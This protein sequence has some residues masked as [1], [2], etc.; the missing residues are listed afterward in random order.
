M[1]KVTA[2]LKQLRHFNENLRTLAEDAEKICKMSL[3]D[4]MTIA[5]DELRKSVEGL[6]TVSNAQALAAYQR[7]E[8]T[9][10]SDRQ[11]AA[12]A[13]GLGVSPMRKRGQA[14]DN[15]V[16]FE[17]YNDVVTRRWPS[18]QP[19]QMIAASCEHGS[20]AMLAQPF[21]RPAFERCRER[22][23]KRMTDTAT[24]EIEKILDK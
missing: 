7:K 9:I 16:G 19:N 23:V 6:R 2:D 17:G 21:I 8:P 20:S 4:G 11:K 3:Y 13:A 1:P 22:I 14:I 12:L 5:A 18:G 10:L 15:K 24:E